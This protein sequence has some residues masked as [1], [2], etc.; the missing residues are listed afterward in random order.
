MSGGNL[1]VTPIR[2]TLEQNIVT[3]RTHAVLMNRLNRETL[4]RHRDRHL[5]LHF[6]YGATARYGYRQRGAKYNAW[7]GKKYGH[8]IPN[9]LTGGTRDKVMSS[10]KI[11]ATRKGGKLRTSGRNF[12]RGQGGLTAEQRSEIEKVIPAERTALGSWMASEYARRATLPEYKRKR[13]RR[14][15]G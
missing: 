4:E 2:F 7:K 6:K 5:P 9:V 3:A 11:T 14:G 15:G 1:M 8:T 12:G 13:R 10:V